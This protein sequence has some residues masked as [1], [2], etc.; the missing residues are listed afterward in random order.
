M[1]KGKGVA[2]HIVDRGA[3]IVDAQTDPYYYTLKD[4]FGFE[5]IQ[6]DNKVA[7]SISDGGRMLTTQGR[8]NTENKVN[9]I[10]IS[11]LYK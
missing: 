1:A 7:D 6:Y 4:E 3:Q 9:V 10:F 8:V 2:F 5:Y 11:V